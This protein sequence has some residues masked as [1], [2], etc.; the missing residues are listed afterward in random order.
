MLDWHPNKNILITGSDEI[1]IFDKK[2]MQLALIY[3]R[4]EP[5]EVL[6]IK[7]HPLGKFFASGDNAH[8]DE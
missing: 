5:A 2:G 7:W 4:D 3:P 6:S 1:M 8:T